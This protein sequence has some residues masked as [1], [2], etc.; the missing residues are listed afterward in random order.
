MRAQANVTDGAQSV[1][2]IPTTP[3][4]A[5]PERKAWYLNGV[6]MLIV[7]IAT[8]VLAGFLAWLASKSHDATAVALAWV[9]GILIIAGLLIMRGLTAVAPGR[10][11]VVQLFGKYRGTI[12][13]PGLQWVNPFTNRIPVSTR[14]RNLESALAKVNDADGNPIERSEE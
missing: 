8:L 13:Q 1:G 4:Q 9:G 11:H 14:I 10:A 7:G 3:S 5:M 6:A 2:S 12:R